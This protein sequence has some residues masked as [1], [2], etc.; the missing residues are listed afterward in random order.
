M[1]MSREIGKRIESRLE[2]LGYWKNGRAD[3][4]RFCR[5][6][7]YPPQYVYSWLKGRVPQFENLI[8][9]GADLAVA[10]AWLLFG[11]N[12]LDGWIGAEVRQFIRPNGDSARDASRPH[13]ENG[14]SDG[15]PRADRPPDREAWDDGRPARGRPGV[16]YRSL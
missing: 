16:R 13:V 9:L 1:R 11:D 5:E 15:S 8:R 14:R 2:A 7:G 4:S 6:R 10:P 12:G 3:V